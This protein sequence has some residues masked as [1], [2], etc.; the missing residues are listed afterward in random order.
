MTEPNPYIDWTDSMLQ[1]KLRRNRL[2]SCFFTF[3]LICEI[4]RRKNISKTE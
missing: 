3:P 2:K 1:A 4:E